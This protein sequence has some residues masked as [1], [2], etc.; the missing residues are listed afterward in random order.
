MISDDFL[1]GFYAVTSFILYIYNADNKIFRMRMMIILSKIMMI[2]LSRIMMIILSRK[3]MRILLS[4]MRMMI[5]L[6]RMRM[7]I[8]MIIFSRML[9]TI[10]LG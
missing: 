8:L 6:S 10:Y 1:A 2:I 9:I 3:M 7:K 4:W 5:I